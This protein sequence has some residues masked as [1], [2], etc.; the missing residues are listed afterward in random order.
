[1]TWTTFAIIWFACGA[2][3]AI[4]QWLD[5]GYIYDTLE[6]SSKE[7]NLEVGIVHVLALLAGPI[8]LVIKIWETWFD[9]SNV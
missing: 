6:Y 1:M 2:V 9:P 5:N 4:W 7:R 3:S 8:G